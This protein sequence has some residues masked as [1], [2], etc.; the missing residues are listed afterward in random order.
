[1]D[2]GESV[3]DGYT[4]T[5]VLSPV[6][7]TVCCILQY[8]YTNTQTFAVYLLYITGLT[9][10]RRMRR[11]EMCTQEQKH[12]RYA[13]LLLLTSL[14]IT[15]A[16]CWLPFNVYYVLVDQQSSSFYNRPHFTGEHRSTQLSS[17]NN[18]ILE[19][20][21]VTINNTQSNTIWHIQS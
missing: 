10:R 4:S 1:V 17:N 8:W 15:F 3:H 16:L 18:G 5:A 9:V 6:D 20:H 7:I 14:I 11:R 13:P 12:N 21:L 19:F 2:H